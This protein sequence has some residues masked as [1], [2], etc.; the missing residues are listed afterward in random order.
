MTI[1]GKENSRF[2]QLLLF[3]SDPSPTPDLETAITLVTAALS[4][5]L[6]TGV[7]RSMAAVLLSFWNSTVTEASIQQR[8]VYTTNHPLGR[9]WGEAAVILCPPLV[10]VVPLYVLGDF[11]QLLIK[12]CDAFLHWFHCL[13]HCEFYIIYNLFKEQKF[14]FRWDNKNAMQ[15]I[16]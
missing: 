13:G 2:S 4:P 14:S 6:C 16:I 3:F 11:V 7:S 5:A 1:P 10:F 15:E 9:R 12:F 8:I